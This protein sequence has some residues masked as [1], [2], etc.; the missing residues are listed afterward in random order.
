MNCVL[1]NVSLR[2]LEGQSSTRNLKSRAILPPPPDCLL[3]FALHIPLERQ[4]G[5]IYII[6]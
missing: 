2:G 4:E 6:A 3:C 1:P 5:T